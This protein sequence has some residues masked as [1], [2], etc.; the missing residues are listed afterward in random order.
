LA[1]VEIL[2]TTDKVMAC[3]AGVEGEGKGAK[4]QSAKRV[5]V[6]EGDAAR[7]LLFSSFRPLI[8]RAAMGRARF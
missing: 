6:S 2:T 3:V 4:K 8:N 1:K 5:S 7:M